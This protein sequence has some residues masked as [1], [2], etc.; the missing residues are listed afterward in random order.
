MELLLVVGMLIA[1]TGLAV[2]FGHDSRY[3]GEPGLFNPRLCC[4]K[5]E[6]RASSSK[7]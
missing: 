2:R 6:L 7:P 1:F 3:D 5:D 4:F